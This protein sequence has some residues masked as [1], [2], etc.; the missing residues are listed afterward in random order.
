M[1]KTDDPRLDRLD[2]RDREYVETLAAPEREVVVSTILR[3]QRQTQLDVG[4]RLPEL[5]LL[6]FPSR[7][8]VRLGD[9]VDGRPLVLVFGSFT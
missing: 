6:A 2:R 5:E 1:T 4:D 8:R 9:L 3:Y 7:A